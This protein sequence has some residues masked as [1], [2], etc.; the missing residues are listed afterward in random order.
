MHHLR[1]RLGSLL[2]AASCRL[3][4]R[5][6]SGESSLVLMIVIVLLLA[7][8]V[9]VGFVKSRR[10]RREDRRHLAAFVGFSAAVVAVIADIVAFAFF[11]WLGEGRMRYMVPAQ[12][13]FLAIPSMIGSVS[14]VV[15]F[16]AGLLSRGGQRVFLVAF[17]IAM[18][19]VYVLT[20]FSN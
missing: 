6:F 16:V 9:A 17:A 4:D 11:Y 3:Y 13:V 19:F 8:P 10:K 5:N 1:A 14:F 7:A 18:A 2:A 15:A 12:R 20:A